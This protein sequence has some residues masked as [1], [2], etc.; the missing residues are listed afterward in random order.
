MLMFLK[1]S[2]KKFDMFTLMKLV[3]YRFDGSIGSPA[4]KSDLTF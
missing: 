1:Q 2:G 3:V 4:M